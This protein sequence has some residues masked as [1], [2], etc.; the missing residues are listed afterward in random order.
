MVTG[1]GA[2]VE[3]VAHAETGMVVPAGEPG[4]MAQQLAWVAGNPAQAAAMGRAGRVWVEQ[5]FSLGAMVAAY[6]GVYQ[7]VLQAHRQE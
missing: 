7:R 1:V 6:E 5:R 2:N 3:L 4:P